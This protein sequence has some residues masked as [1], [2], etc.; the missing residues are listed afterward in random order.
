MYVVIGEFA[1][2]LFLDLL[3]EMDVPGC[4]FSW[5]YSHLESRWPNKALSKLL[6]SSVGRDGL[7]QGM[8]HPK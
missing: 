5:G 3:D 2:E 8:I 7:L 1:S 6:V 4:C